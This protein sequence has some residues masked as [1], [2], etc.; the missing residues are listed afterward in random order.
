[1]V[2]RL[3]ERGA[4]INEPDSEGFYVLHRLVQDS[5]KNDEIL[6]LLVGK[7]ANLN[8]KCPNIGTALHI[9]L[10]GQR[11][12]LAKKLV[13]L[14]ADVNELDFEGLSVLHIIAAQKS[15]YYES[16]GRTSLIHLLITKG[17][18][19]N[20]IEHVDEPD[21]E[22][23]TILHRLAGRSYICVRYISFLRFLLDKGARCDTLCPSGDSAI[24][25]AVQ[26]NNWCILEELLRD[27]IE[28]QSVP[29]ASSKKVCQVVDKRVGLK[30]TRSS[31]I[32]RKECGRAPFNINTKDS[33]GNTVLHLSAK[34][35]NWDQVHTL[36]TCGADAT[37]TDDEGLTV[38]YRLATADDALLAKGA[39]INS[40]DENGRT[41]LFQSWRNMRAHANFF[42]SYALL[43]ALL[44]RGA[45][46]LIADCNGIS[47]LRDVLDLDGCLATKY[48][49]FFI[50]RGI[51]TYQPALTETFSIPSQSGSIHVSTRSPTQRAF[52]KKFVKAFEMLVESGASS[53]RELFELSTRY[54]VE[55][56][57]RDKTGAE[58]QMLDIVNHAASQPRSL[59]SLCRLTVSHAL[60]CDRRRMDRVKSLHFLLHFRIM[61]YS[62]TYFLLNYHLQ[63][64]KLKI[65]TSRGQNLV[66]RVS[67]LRTP[68]GLLS[69]ISEVTITYPPVTATVMIQTTI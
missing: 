64:T 26:H 63:Q 53:N 18:D 43:R 19:S 7:G 67:H 3:V 38:L 46:P 5:D 42:A 37:L 60:G 16:R 20:G 1:M 23:F 48:V 9:A 57:S 49:Q 69:M 58:T 27:K 24:H 45:S 34:A 61:S 62:L 32:I 2:K 28:T 68:H 35:T 33:Q 39:D 15:V 30:R 8:Y 51:S 56:S 29:L 54:Q 31:K 66:F 17:A 41:I 25:L 13:Q 10:K 11:W 36:L 44:D 4:N 14:G 50:E 52:E 22:G 21:T 47:I 40:R 65:C 6:E 55:L 12:S 59:K